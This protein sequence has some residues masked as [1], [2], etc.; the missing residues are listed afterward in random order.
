MFC[1]SWL[2]ALFCYGASSG[3]SHPGS[4]PDPQPS[5]QQGW[6]GGLSG[7]VRMGIFWYFAMQIFGP[8]KTTKPAELTS[9]LFNKGDRLMHVGQS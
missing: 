6:A 2:V 8:K 3:T 5:A 1:C 4:E 9:N 7:I